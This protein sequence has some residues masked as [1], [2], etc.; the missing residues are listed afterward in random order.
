MHADDATRS[1]LS[2]NK[3]IF[4]KKECMGTSESWINKIYLLLND[5]AL[6][7]A[8]TGPAADRLLYKSVR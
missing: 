5:A 4:K 2:E 8:R 1:F 6:K 3:Y 7:R